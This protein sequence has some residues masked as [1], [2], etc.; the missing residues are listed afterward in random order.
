VKAWQ[1]HELHREAGVRESKQR[2]E[3]EMSRIMTK[4]VDIIA[5]SWRENMLFMRQMYLEA[6]SAKN[7]QHITLCAT[8][9]CNAMSPF[10]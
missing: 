10:W 1:E 4:K 6:V 3:A 5:L 2:F 9:Q 8:L 7:L